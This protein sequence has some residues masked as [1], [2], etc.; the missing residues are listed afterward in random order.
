MRFSRRARL[1]AMLM[2]AAW[3]VFRGVVVVGVPVQSLKT[4]M[5]FHW[6]VTRG[7]G[8]EAC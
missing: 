7:I 8:P 5:D 6:K 4:K 3:L 1:G 2:A